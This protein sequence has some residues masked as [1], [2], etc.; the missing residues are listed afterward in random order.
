M[1]D[2]GSLKNST[3]QFVLKKML[4]WLLLFFGF[5]ICCCCA[6]LLTI[7]ITISFLFTTIPSITQRRFNFGILKSEKYSAKGISLPILSSDETLLDILYKHLP[8]LQKRLYDEKNNKELT[9]DPVCFFLF[10]LGFF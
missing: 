10:I 9:N 6:L 4:W 7:S 3:N 5:F 8:K 1:I 2:V